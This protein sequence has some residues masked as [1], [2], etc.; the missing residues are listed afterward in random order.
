LAERGVARTWGRQHTPR[1]PAN[2]KNVLDVFTNLLNFLPDSGVTDMMT[3]MASVLKQVATVAMAGLEGLQSMRPDGEF[4]KRMDTSPRGRHEVFCA[5]GE[6]H[7]R[8]PRPAALRRVVRVEPVDQRRQ[9]PG[10]AD[11][12]VFAM[13]GSGLF[14]IEEKLVREGDAAVPHTTDSENGAVHRK[15]REWPGTGA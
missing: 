13:N 7:P 3:L 14:P 10:G 8:G 12:G 2:L 9:R 11:Q 6:R 15:I 4:A 5:G 1:D